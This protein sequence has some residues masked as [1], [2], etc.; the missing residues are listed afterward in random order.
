MFPD[1][2]R[3]I[4][5]AETSFPNR[6]VEAMFSSAYETNIFKER[7]KLIQVLLYLT[8]LCW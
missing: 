3:N 5:V 6:N 1:K 7:L 8:L 2:L 4:F